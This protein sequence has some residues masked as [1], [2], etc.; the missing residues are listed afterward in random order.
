L[1]YLEATKNAVLD[2]TTGLSEAQWNFKPAP[3]CWSVAEI[4]EHIAVSED[5]IRGG[6]EQVTRTPARPVRDTAELKRIDDAVL[7][8]TPDRTIK[9]QIPERLRPTNRFGSPTAAQQHFIESRATTEN[10]LKNTADLRAH[11]GWSPSEKAAPTNPASFGNFDAYQ[12]I[13]FVGAHSERHIKQ[14]LEVKANPNFP[15]T[16]RG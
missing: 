10:L 1:A 15:K 3:E 12:W 8:H 11:Y 14:I 6:A 7:T 16:P 9:R 4:M 13:L 5:H 2:A